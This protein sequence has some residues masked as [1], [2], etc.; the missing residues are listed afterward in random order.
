M[1]DDTNTVD[2]K[3]VWK[4]SNSLDHLHLFASTGTAAFI[5][6]HLP[7]EKAVAYQ[8]THLGSLNAGAGKIMGDM[9]N[10]VDGFKIKPKKQIK[11]GYKIH[12]KVVRAS[13]PDRDGDLTMLIG[14]SKMYDVAV[15]KGSFVQEAAAGTYACV[16]NYPGLPPCACPSGAFVGGGSGAA[17]HEV[18]CTFPPTRP[19]PAQLP[20]NPHC[21]R[22]TFVHVTISHTNTPLTSRYNPAGFYPAFYPACEIDGNKVSNRDM[23]LCPYLNPGHGR[24]ILTWGE[25]PSDMDVSLDAPDGKGGR[26]TVMYKDKFCQQVGKGKEESRIHLDHDVT[27]GYGP[28]TLTIEGFI[29]GEY[30]LRVK[31]GLLLSRGLGCRV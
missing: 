8:T 1:L 5:G 11:T 30:L 22:V 20:P 23:V 12:H 15:S 13:L 21:C 6:D 29:P 4:S 26:C 14:S 25:E 9:M 16:A 10:A 18:P 2:F 28:E 7:I 24:F 3:F 31:V 19:T 27:K 17:L